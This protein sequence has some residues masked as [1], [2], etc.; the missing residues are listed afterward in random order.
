MISLITRPSLW[1]P[2]SDN[3]LV[4][5]FHLSRLFKERLKTG[6][7]TL[8]QDESASF[9]TPY[10]EVENPRPALL[11]ALN[12]YAESLRATA[13]FSYSLDALAALKH[14]RLIISIERL[15]DETLDLW[16]AL[17]GHLLKHVPDKGDAVIIAECG[18]T[19]LALLKRHD[20]TFIERA[21]SF[22]KHARLDKEA[23]LL[24]ASI[25]LAEDIKTHDLKKEI[26]EC[27]RTVDASHHNTQP[28][29]AKA[30]C[31]LYQRLAC[32]SQE[33]VAKKCLH[34]ARLCRMIV[35]D[36]AIEVCF[37]FGTQHTIYLPRSI[38]VMPESAEK[39][40]QASSL[41]A[42]AY[43]L[44]KRGLPERAY[45]ALCKVSKEEDL[46]DF[47]PPL[48]RFTFFFAKA[49][50]R[51]ALPREIC[52]VPIDDKE[53]PDIANSSWQTMTF[54]PDRAAILAAEK[55]RSMITLTKETEWAYK[56][57]KFLSDVHHWFTTGQGAPTALWKESEK[58]QALA[59]CRADRLRLS[60]LQLILTMRLIVDPEQREPLVKS[61]DPFLR[62]SFANYFC[63]PLDLLR[64]CLIALESSYTFDA[65]KQALMADL[66]AFIPLPQTPID[67]EKHWIVREALLSHF[68]FHRTR[69]LALARQDI[70]R[71]LS[72]KGLTFEKPDPA[73]FPHLAR[74]GVFFVRQVDSWVGTFEQINGYCELLKI[75][76]E[77]ITHAADQKA[78]LATTTL[79]VHS[80]QLASLAKKFPTILA[81]TVA[82]ALSYVDEVRS[83]IETA[84][85]PL[86]VENRI[87]RRYAV[88]NISSST[89]YQ[90]YQSPPEALPL[91]H[92]YAAAL[93]FQQPFSYN[94]KTLTHI[95]HMR[96]RLEEETLPLDT[97]KLWFS[98][99]Q[100]VLKHNPDKSHWPLLATCGLLLLEQMNTHDSDFLESI[101]DILT[102]PMTPEEKMP[103][104][105]QFFIA[106]SRQE[107]AFPG[108]YSAL[109][110]LKNIRDC[111]IF[112]STFTK[113]H[114]PR[115]AHIRALLHNEMARLLEDLDHYDNA[116]ES[117]EAALSCPKISY[118]NFVTTDN[119]SLIYL[120]KTESA[121][122]L[123]ERVR[124]FIALASFARN[125]EDYEKAIKDL[126]TIQPLIP[127]DPAIQD[128]LKEYQMIQEAIAARPSKETLTLRAKQE[129]TKASRLFHEGAVQKAIDVLNKITD[130][131]DRFWDCEEHLSPQERFTIFFNKAH[132]AL[133]L[134]RRIFIAESAAK[135]DEGLWYQHSHL[136]C[137]SDVAAA[138]RAFQ[139]LSPSLE[140][141]RSFKLVKLIS[142]VREWLAS[143]R[144]DPK[145]LWKEAQSLLNSGAEAS[146]SERLRIQEQQ[147][148]LTLA[149][150]PEHESHKVSLL[151]AL[152][153]YL[154]D[155]CADFFLYPLNFLKVCLIG[156]EKGPDYEKA[157]SPYIPARDAVVTSEQVYT[158]KHALQIMVKMNKH[159]NRSSEVRRD[160]LHILTL[161][162]IA[163]SSPNLKL[164]PYLAR[165][166]VFLSRTVSFM[167]EV[168]QA[169]IYIDLIKVEKKMIETAATFPED[170]ALSLVAHGAKLRKLEPYC[171]KDD[172]VIAMN[173]VSEI[174]GLREL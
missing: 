110:L 159:N 64:V 27:L 95:K 85:P 31:F 41:C 44:F 80:Q 48:E 11:P 108:S 126:Q 142:D 100:C 102:L 169:K 172:F 145:I 122:S 6:Y 139:E 57:V 75:E 67:S 56:L 160:L 84:I 107:R 97:L 138:D 140:P 113:R 111:A 49:R 16:F 92:N 19:L 20:Q 73:R 33:L 154:Q 59:T 112:F 5:P 170:L 1:P 13:S 61:L 93:L 152:S 52:I 69:D 161:K 46:F 29:L 82:A 34:D 144:G 128:L 51:L 54:H 68:L 96:Y 153:P 65:R 168:S 104:C 70:L 74:T 134:P 157:L 14:F 133:F 45:E 158:V 151:K 125:F 35:F 148:V 71:F 91:L 3:K 99:I 174:E 143:N 155:S 30:R 62:P 28:T 131:R 105:S 90:E 89:E 106:M 9:I 121:L 42:A 37:P 50:Y 2:S 146:L 15:P 87:V 63:F 36:N 79:L 58:L 10:H 4:M 162:K 66:S 40:L 123:K 137:A 22:L 7:I 76:K 47:L 124:I 119:G 81:E 8:T 114:Q 77:M 83:L 72:Y 78:A 129:L 109:I 32:L 132:Y 18:C 17:V 164:F 136:P 171:K 39:T 156:L 141:P 94:E 150:P 127:D 115:W 86:V 117:Y 165:D 149:V 163:L 38:F 173:Y 98:L 120:Y 88:S 60:E 116:K 166:H 23:L 25:L 12:N 21:R 101:K 103:L 147:L 130:R 24:Q 43:Q 167:N 118:D 26:E 55:L 135:V 53:S